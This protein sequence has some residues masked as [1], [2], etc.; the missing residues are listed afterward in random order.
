MYALVLLL[1]QF[2]KLSRTFFKLTPHFIRTN[3][4]KTSSHLQDTTYK[5]IV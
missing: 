2:G 4:L 5:F 1:I 3:N